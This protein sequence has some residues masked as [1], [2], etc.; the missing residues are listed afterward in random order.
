M[1]QVAVGSLRT[2]C[3][4]HGVSG[5]CSLRTCWKALAD[6]MTVGAELQQRYD[7]QAVQVVVRRAANISVLVPVG[8]RQMVT[9]DDFV[10]DTL[11]P[12][13]C[14]P[15][16]ASGSY[17]TQHRSADKPHY[18]QPDL[19]YQLLVKTHAEF[20]SKS[21]LWSRLNVFTMTSILIMKHLISVL[22]DICS[23]TKMF[24]SLSVYKE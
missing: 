18:T 8:P 1:A 15:D 2:D 10:Y 13:Y 21:L 3:K 11:S 19:I 20:R 9:Y 6:V 22:C 23:I 4:C 14:W 16:K 5:S 12:D 7:N 17:G 24:M